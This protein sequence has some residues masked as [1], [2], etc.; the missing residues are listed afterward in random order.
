MDE[1]LEPKEDGYKEKHQKD[2]IKEMRI[3]IDSIKYH[4]IPQV[5]YKETPKKCMREGTSTKR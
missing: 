1:F 5:S 2:L 4:F 3:T